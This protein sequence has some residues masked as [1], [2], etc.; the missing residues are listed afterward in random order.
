MTIGSKEGPPPPWPDIHRTVLSTLDALASSTGWIPTAATVGIEPVFERVLQQICQPQ[1]VSP[2][3]YIDVITRDAG[4][5]REVQ[6]RLA[7]LMETPAL[8]NMR[9]EAQRREAEHQLHVL[10]FVLSGQE[11]PDWVMS[12]IDEEQQQQLRDAAES[13]EERDPVLLP[14]V[15]RALRKLAADPTTYGQCE[16]C[17]TTILLERLQLVPWAECCAACQRK[18]EGVPDVAPEPEVAVTYF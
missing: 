1:G 15:Q 7:R 8:V 5:R 17:G 16:D 6:K 12:T 11:P 9:R 18:R 4:M 3:A 14:R 10:H 2:E 13:G